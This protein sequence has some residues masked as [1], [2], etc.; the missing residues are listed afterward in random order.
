M[1]IDVDL[2]KN[3]NIGIRIRQEIYDRRQLQT[4]INI[5]IHNSQG[6]VWPR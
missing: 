1:S 4:T 3:E 2:L 6:T 5:P